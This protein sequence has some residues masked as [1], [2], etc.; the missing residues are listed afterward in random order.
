MAEFFVAPKPT[1]FP[2]PEKD[3]HGVLIVA[4]ENIIQRLDPQRVIIRPRDRP[5]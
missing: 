4:P 2:V 1:E 3:N 5:A